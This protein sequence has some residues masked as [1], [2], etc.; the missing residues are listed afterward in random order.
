MARDATDSHSTYPRARA[1]DDVRTGGRGSARGNRSMGAGG[2]C[3]PSIGSSG[4]S[5]E[6]RLKQAARLLYLA[7]IDVAEE[8]AMKEAA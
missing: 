4:M 6:E 3:A 8:T 7:A 1:D 2:S 5:P